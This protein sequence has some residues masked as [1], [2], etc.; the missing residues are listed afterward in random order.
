MEFPQQ[1]IGHPGHGVQP[2]RDARLFQAL[3]PET[4]QNDGFVPSFRHAA[5]ITDGK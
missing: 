2:G 1:D 3:M 4:R 5:R